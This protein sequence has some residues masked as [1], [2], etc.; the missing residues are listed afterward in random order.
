MSRACSLA[1][2]VLLCACTHEGTRERA[3]TGGLELGEWIVLSS[4][5]GNA[6]AIVG[7]QTI[8]VGR[9]HAVIWSGTSRL[10]SIDAMWPS[11]GRPRVMGDRVGWGPNLLWL[12]S[13]KLE[14]REAAVPEPVPMDRGDVAF[15]YAWSRDGE[16]L[17]RSVSTYEDGARVTLHHGDT[18]KQAAMLWTAH[19]LAPTALWLGPSWLAIGLNP[20]R[21]VDLQ[22]QPRATLELDAGTITQLEASRDESLLIAVD[23][24]R[25]ITLFDTSSW[26]VAGRWPGTWTDASIAPDGSMVAGLEMDGT[27]RLA[28]ASTSGMQELRTLADIEGAVSVHLGEAAIA[29]VGGGELRRASLRGGCQ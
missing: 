4:E 7:E 19:T 3:A 9:G 25:S 15:A 11:V 1:V 18:G 8:A 24:N 16:W 22:G 23:L 17:A 2:V 6:A 28:C 27:L 20:P 5:S 21:V 26:T 12:D 14:L 10:T 13:G 29:V